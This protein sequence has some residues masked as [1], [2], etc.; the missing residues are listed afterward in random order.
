MSDDN[1]K[2]LNEN[3]VLKEKLDKVQGQ[4][5][6]LTKQNGELTDKNAKLLEEI[7]AM[8]AEKL[9]VFF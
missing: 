5:A 2:L 9:Q 6:E 7:E 1:S 8:K 4:N 3:I